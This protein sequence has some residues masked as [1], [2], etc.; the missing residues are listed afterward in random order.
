V[1]DLRNIIL[2]IVVLVIVVN[3]LTGHGAG[4]ALSITALLGTVSKELQPVLI[5]VALPALLVGGLIYVSPWHRD[6]AVRLMTG[7]AVVLAVA[8]L[9]PLALHWLEVQLVN[10]GPSL[11]GG[12]P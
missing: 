4:M 1:K 8:V 5:A 3:V 2:G 10:Y 7:A 9:G 11:F 6:L 12:K